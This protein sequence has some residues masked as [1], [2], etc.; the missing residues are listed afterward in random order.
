MVLTA[1]LAGTAIFGV[2]LVHAQTD[3]NNRFS[4]LVAAIAKKFNLDQTQVQAVVTDY[5]N[6]ERTQMEQKRQQMETDKLTKLVTDGKITETQK[7][8]IITEMAALKAKYNPSNFKDLTADQRKTQMQTEKDEITAW[9]K[10]N[11]IDKKYLMMGRGPGFDGGMGKHGDFQGKS[12][13]PTP[14][15]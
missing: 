5:Q 13:M 7:Q 12:P 14:T 8:A 11:N 15:N 4:G 6:T 2:S 9:A 10:A 1:A 3:N